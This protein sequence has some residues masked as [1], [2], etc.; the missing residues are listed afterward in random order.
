MTKTSYFSCDFSFLIFNVIQKSELLLS[1][2]A[3]L[4]CSLRE[5]QQNQKRFWWARATS[6]LTKW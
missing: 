2:C 3:S 6:H 1:T 4:Y 5:S